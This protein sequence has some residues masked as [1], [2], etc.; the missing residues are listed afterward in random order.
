MKPQEIGP[1]QGIE[2]VESYPQLCYDHVFG[3][4]RGIENHGKER[5]LGQGSKCSQ[6]DH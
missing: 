6:K 2:V 4:L 5:T 3:Y 1:C